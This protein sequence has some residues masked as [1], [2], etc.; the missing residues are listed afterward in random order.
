METRKDKGKFKMW[1]ARAT[2]LLGLASLS[3]LV[4]AGF[5]VK[6]AVNSYN[7]RRE[8][9]LEEPRLEVVSEME[10]TMPWRNELSYLSVEDVRGDDEGAFLEWKRDYERNI[11]KVRTYRKLYDEIGSGEKIDRYQNLEV[12]AGFQVAGAFSCGMMALAYGWLN[13]RFASI[14]RRKDRE[15]E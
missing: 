4:G 2:T 5:G 10:R 11:E 7:L 13:R 9:L 1:E 8:M 12:W 14:E 3:L 15:N 6:G